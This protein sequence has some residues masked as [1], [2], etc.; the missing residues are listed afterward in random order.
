MLVGLLGAS[1][2]S[3]LFNHAALVILWVIQEFI[4]INLRVPGIFWEAEPRLDWFGPAMLISL[5]VLLLVAY[6]IGSR[7][8]L[9]SVWRPRRI[10]DFWS[11]L[12]GRIKRIRLYEKRL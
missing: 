5:L 10:S 2:L 4:E 12:S 1:F 3:S 11:D 7:T 8:I 6:S 9:R